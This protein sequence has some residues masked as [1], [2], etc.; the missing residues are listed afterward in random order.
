MS[1]EGRGS[2]SI[3]GNLSKVA[4]LGIGIAAVAT[5]AL[6]GC[7]GSGS[8]GGSSS[9]TT[10]LGAAANQFLADTTVGWGANLG[11]TSAAGTPSVVAWAVTRSF[12]AISANSYTAN[13]SEM[14]LAT[15]SSVWLSAAKS[16]NWETYYLLA[17]G[18]QPTDYT[19]ANYTNNG[20][21]TISLTTRNGLYRSEIS[22][23]TRT[24][25]SGKPVVCTNPLGSYSV[26][27]NIG[28]A[29]NPSIVTAAN[30]SVAVTYPAG[31]VAY[32]Y[33]SNDTLT[34][35]YYAQ[36]NSLYPETLTDETGVA[37]STFPSMG[38]RFCLNSYVYDP[39]SGAAAGTDNYKV[40]FSS[41]QCTAAG[42]DSALT[43]GSPRAALVSIKAKGNAAVPNLLSIRATFGTAIVDELY[44]FLSGKLIRVWYDPGFTSTSTS[45]AFNRTAANAQLRANGLPPLP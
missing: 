18:W 45:T 30:C 23:I 29:S 34:E 7:G 19:P 8:S 41:S 14:E 38:A 32:T 39:I 36:P 16:S 4:E 31:S 10:V 15:S 22:S 25:L 12:D 44:A 6:A 28:S 40:Y 37:L 35:Y 5:L 2:M 20:N 17:T 3:K 43:N 13:S 26:G 9:S 27:E 24:D 42:I 33:S 1:V 21:G 11:S